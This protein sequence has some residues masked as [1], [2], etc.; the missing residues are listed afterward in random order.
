MQYI[1]FCSKFKKAP[2]ELP[3]IDEIREQYAYLADDPVMVALARPQ[4]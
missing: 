1:T 2:K 4:E 3:W